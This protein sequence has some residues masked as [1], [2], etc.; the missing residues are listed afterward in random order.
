M[1][2]RVAWFAAAA[3]FI[4]G[5]AML[6]FLREGLPGL[7]AEQRVAFMNARPLTWMGGWLLWHVAAL[8]LIALYVALAMRF[9]DVL[10]VTAV[11]A[12]TAALAIDIACEAKYIGVLPSL[13]GDE[14]H[15]LDRELEVLIGYAANGLYTVAFILLVVA[16]W[17][18]L[19]KLALVLAGP[20]AGSGV[21]LALASLRH[22]ARLQT[23]TTALLFLSLIAWMVVIAQWLRSD[24]SS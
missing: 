14:F 11:A 4:A 17:R 8:S 24:A 5:V 19:P 7:A 16:G 3:H 10:S 2:S 15:R 18:V 23:V 9:R 21:A 6:L 1:H 12:A 20:V 13:R 22:D